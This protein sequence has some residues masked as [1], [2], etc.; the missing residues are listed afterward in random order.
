MPKVITLEKAADGSYYVPDN[1]VV[2]IEPDVET[3]AVQA[4]P[5]ILERRV[6]KRPARRRKENKE[7]H[8]FIVKHGENMTQ[9]LDG[10][11]KTLKLYKIIKRTLR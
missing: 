9:F 3:K 1:P 6:C 5:E 8:E 10:V 4:E 11:Q 2:E 7:V